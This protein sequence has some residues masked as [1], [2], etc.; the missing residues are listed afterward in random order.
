MPMVVYCMCATVIIRVSDLQCIP[1]LG[2]A[3]MPVTIVA[4]SNVHINICGLCI[5]GFIT[6]IK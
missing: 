6:T 3:H 5:I 2:Y 1:L 4:T